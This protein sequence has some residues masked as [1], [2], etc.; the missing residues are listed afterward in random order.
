MGFSAGWFPQGCRA[1][2]SQVHCQLQQKNNKE[3]IIPMAILVT[4]EVGEGRL[5]MVTIFCCSDQAK[6]GPL[7]T[8]LTLL[9]WDPPEPGILLMKIFT[10]S[11]YVPQGPFSFP[12]LDVTTLLVGASTAQFPLAQMHLWRL[13]LYFSTQGI[14]PWEKEGD[15]LKVIPFH[16]KAL[17][18]VQVRTIVVPPCTTV[19]PHHLLPFI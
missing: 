19:S 18:R 15:R 3:E 1:G 10:N 12:Y 13:L 14:L 2:Q 5:G 9:Q 17:G 16:K 8:P 6:V 7:V 11:L 4:N